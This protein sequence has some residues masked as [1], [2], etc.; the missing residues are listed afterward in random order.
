[1]HRHKKAERVNRFCSDKV[2]LIFLNGCLVASANRNVI[3]RGKKPKRKSKWNA[4]QKEY[5][6]LEFLTKIVLAANA[7][8]VAI[9]G[10]PVGDF[11]LVGIAVRN[12]RRQVP[13]G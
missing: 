8:S 9:F 5:A 6:M 3:Y 11:A 10:K 2:D 13:R 4:T 7:M 12:T 1:L